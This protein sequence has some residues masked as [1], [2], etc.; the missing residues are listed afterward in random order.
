MS[1]AEGDSM[2]KIPS[3]E[4]SMVAHGIAKNVGTEIGARDSERALQWEGKEGRRM[5]LE[6]MRSVSQLRRRGSVGDMAA[7]MKLDFS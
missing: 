7:A 3:H 5:R 6:K 4:D 1:P 2:R